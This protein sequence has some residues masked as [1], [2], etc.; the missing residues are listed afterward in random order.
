M[1]LP[2]ILRPDAEADVQEI[3]ESMEQT[4]ERLGKKFLARLRE[5]LERIESFPEIYGV[6]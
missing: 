5:L 1:S 4:R 3:Y 6:V 2:V